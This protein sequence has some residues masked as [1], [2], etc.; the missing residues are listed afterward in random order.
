MEQTDLCFTSASQLAGL[1]QSRE[2]SPVELME[3]LLSRIEHLQPQIN[4]FSTVCTDKAMEASRSAESEIV[5]GKSVGPLHGI[6]FSVKDL[7]WTKGVPTTSGS[8]IFENY[9]P[10]EDAPCVQ[11]LK[12]AGG[13]LIGKTTTPE[14]GHKA[15]TDSPLFGITRNP[16]NLDRTPGGSSGGAAAL[17]AAGLGPLAIG[18]DGGGSVRIP[19]SCSGIVGLKPTLGRIPH[20]Q[21]LD[22]F[23]TLSHVGPMTRTVA[24]AALMFEVMAGPEVRDPYSYGLPKETYRSSATGDVRESLKGWKIAWSPTLGNTEVDSEVL[25]LIEAAVQVFVE[26]GC[27]LEEARPDFDLPEE[28]YL[29]LFHAGLAAR[30]DPYLERFREKM[31]PSLLNAIERGCQYSAVDLQRASY[32]RT[33]LF[34]AVQQFFSRFD[35]LVTPTLSAPALPVTHNALEPVAVNGKIAGTMRAAWYPYT[36]PFNMAGNP[37]V[38]IPCGWTRENLPVGLQIVGPWLAEGSI[39]KA[40]AAFELERPWAGRRPPL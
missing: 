14:F 13:I 39:L 6:P 20:P 29:T 33:Q 21:S 24:D 26:F 4:A 9:L 28:P 40:A 8:Y 34:Q 18:T 15:I 10:D 23:G 36:Y 5:R 30:L 32:V 3:A 11:R 1:I 27:E 37:A 7:L 38:S 2:I 25:E 35:L 22:V 16:W 31:D 12:E 19:A 17:I